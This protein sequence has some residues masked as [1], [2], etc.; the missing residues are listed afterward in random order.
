VIRLRHKRIRAVVRTNRTTIDGLADAVRA[1][2]EHRLGQIAL[3]RQPSVIVKVKA[4]RS[5]R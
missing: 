1:A 3:A 2:I 5:T 4:T